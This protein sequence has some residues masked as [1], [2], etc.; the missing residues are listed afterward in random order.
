MASG[1]SAE[2]EYQLILSKDLNYISEHTYKDLELELVEIRKMLHS[3]I[4]KL[5]DN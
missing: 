3:F 1:S 2:L 4:K 5:P